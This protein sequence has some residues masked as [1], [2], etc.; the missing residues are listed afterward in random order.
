MIYKI[1]ALL[2][3]GV[4]IWGLWQWLRYRGSSRVEEVAEQ[5]LGMTKTR[6]IR[7]AQQNSLPYRIAGEDDT[8][9]FLTSDYKPNRINFHVRDGKVIDYE[10]K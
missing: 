7:H 3:L 6:A 2:V 5:T 4:G 8:K 1:T 9:Y 10:I